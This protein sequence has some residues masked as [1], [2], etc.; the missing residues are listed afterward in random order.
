MFADMMSIRRCAVTF[1]ALGGMAGRLEAFAGGT[2]TA[3]D[4]Y[5]IA[6]A[7][8]LTS[9]GADPNLPD[10][11]YVLLNDLDLD[12]NLPGGQAFTRAV[13]APNTGLSREFE[14]T[15]F[16]GT[17]DGGRH[18]VKGLVIHG[19]SGHF[20]G[21]LGKVGEHGWVHNLRVDGAIVTGE[22]GCHYLGILAGSVQGGTITNCR[23][24][25]SIFAGNGIRAAGGLAGFV[26]FSDISIGRIMQCSGAC[27][28]YV[29]EDG[30]GVGGLVGTNAGGFIADCSTSGSVI[31]GSRSKS[32]GGL[33]GSHDGQVI[34]H[35][36]ATGCVR[37]G[38]KSSGL[39]G[40]V[41]MSDY[42]GETYDSFWDIEAS[43]VLVSDGGTGVSTLQMLDAL[44]FRDAG[45]DL[46]GERS[47]GTAELWLISD[48]GGYPALAVLYEG[49]EPSQLPGAGT[50]EDPY[51]IATPEDLGTVNHYSPHANYQLV[52]DINLAGITWHRAPIAYFDGR[53]DGAGFLMSNLN[54][55]GKHD[56]ALFGTL[57]RHA[58]VENLG[59]RDVSITGKSLL[60][61]LAALNYG[62]V[63]RC[64]GTGNIV[65][66][67]AFGGLVGW[68]RGI[69]THSYSTGTVSGGQVGLGMGGLAGY[70]Y[71]MICECYA[72]AEISWSIARLS[73]GG[74]VG[75]NVEGRISDCYF[76][77]GADGHGRDNGLGLPLTGE[78]MLHEANF[79][80]WDFENIWMICEGRDYPRLRWEGI[81]C[82]E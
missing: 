20:L 14:G 69:I 61:S 7:E 65:G 33:V 49:Y 71:G 60:G 68:N 74:L 54:V 73:P 58:S 75:E 52:A 16:T 36:F 8:Q 25:G 6:T 51:R 43:G 45:W 11:H 17:F 70:N 37:G 64:H 5:G 41:G 53:F 82:E 78:Q 32:L 23:V 27:D 47:N 34:R 15:P 19:D 66:S 28:V 50:R 62:T 21:L 81:Q 12:P 10:K 48:G 67:G 31:G 26:G 55:T 22:S 63:M 42:P 77:L 9:I 29:E 79:A 44:L 57:A 13:I 56:L 38:E 4:P 59:I 76:L 80:G 1:L 2:G 35:C 72:A 40:L 3:E 24:R 39:G 30:K 46:A 18:T